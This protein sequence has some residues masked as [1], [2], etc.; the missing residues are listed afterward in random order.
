[1]SA[2]FL[3]G[4]GE[5][6]ALLRV[7]RRS[8]LGVFFRH[9]CLV[10]FVAQAIGPPPKKDAGRVTRVTAIP[11]DKLVVEA[12]RAKAQPDTEPKGDLSDRAV[13]DR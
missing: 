7:V 11:L 5:M 6:G 1:V 12:I 4:G 9:P 3:A 13:I 10:V 8:L 2:D